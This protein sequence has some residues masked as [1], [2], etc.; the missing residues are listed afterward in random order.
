MQDFQFVQ[1]DQVP[2]HT[3][4]HIHTHTHTHK[5]TSMS[6]PV[7]SRPYPWQ[8]TPSCFPLQKSMQTS[9][10]VYLTALA[11][12][13]SIKLVNDTLYFLT[14]LLLKVRACVSVATG[15]P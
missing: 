5:Q 13:D 4:T 15:S 7:S 3:H 11:V 6:V 12:A 14:V 10:N 2:T 9:T 1:S 8:P